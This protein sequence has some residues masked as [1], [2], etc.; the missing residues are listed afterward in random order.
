VVSV[1]WITSIEE[2]RQFFD[3][4]GWFEL[5]NCLILS[6]P[7]GGSAPP[8]QVELVLRDEITSN[9]NA[10]VRT[11]Q[12]TR[13]TATGVHEYTFIG[14]EFHHRTDHSVEI[15]ELIENSLGY[16]LGLDVPTF[17]WVVA[18]TFTCERLPE[19]TEPMPPVGGRQLGGRHGAASRGAVSVAVGDRARGARRR[20]HMAGVR[21][22]RRAGRSRPG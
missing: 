20:G 3:D 21:R 11:F 15:A 6:P 16:G 14:E 13:I 17:V 22:R 19:V 5:A 18:D 10:K 1:Q 2:L 7:P 8:E 9:V 4:N 12:I